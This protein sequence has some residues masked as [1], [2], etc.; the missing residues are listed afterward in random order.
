M[1]IHVY[2]QQNRRNTI[3]GP[4][5]TVIKEVIGFGS[6]LVD[7]MAS[8]EE[9]IIK[10]Y[11]LIKNGM[12]LVDKEKIGSL[13]KK[14]N[15]EKKAPGGSALNTISGLARLGIN[16][17]FVGKIEKDEMGDFLIESLK[18][19]KI[20]NKM[21]F[22]NSLATGRV[23]SIIT[24]D[25]ER[26]FATYLGCASEISLGD[27]KEDLFHKGALIYLE[28]YLIL[29]PGLLDHICR[30]AKSAG[31]RLSMDLSSFNIV[32]D[33]KSQF[34]D[35]LDKYIDIV[36]ANEEEA[37]ALTGKRSEESLLLLEKKC[38]IAVVKKGKSGSLASQD[39]QRVII[40]TDVV[41]AKDT[42]GAGDLY[43]AGFLFGIINNYPLDICGKIASI[44]SREVVKIYGTSMADNTWENIIQEINNLLK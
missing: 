12:T 41:S 1:K 25:K 7:I 36:F 23:I 22:S 20:K 33:F 44:T 13:V 5:E 14:V 17:S 28:G 31:A 29:R 38:N 11:H 19:S 2:W 10:N 4:G 27:I 34:L 9:N 39:S 26:S 37:E 8:G 21:I 42:T 3:I 18:K 35:L 24:P 15:I 32:Q 16:T 30:L 6:P 43:A 40:K